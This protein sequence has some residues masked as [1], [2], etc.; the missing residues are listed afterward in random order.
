[1]TQGGPFESTNLLVYY[2]YENGFK[3]WNRGLGSAMT[4]VLTVFLLIVTVII[5]KTIGKKVYYESE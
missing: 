4:T 1:M 3:F 2:I 5:F